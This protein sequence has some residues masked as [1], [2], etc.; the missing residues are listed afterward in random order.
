MMMLAPG[1]HQRT[2]DVREA[3]YARLEQCLQALSMRYRRECAEVSPGDAKHAALAKLYAGAQR[4]HQAVREGAVADA[5][6]EIGSN[7]MG[8][9]Q[10]AVMVARGKRKNIAF[11][12]SVGLNRKQLKAVRM[13][14]REIIEEAATDSVYIA[15]DGQRPNPV[16]QSLGITA[17][18]PF[19]LDYTTKGAIAFFELL[20]QR[21]GLDSTD[22]ELLTLLGA[23]AGPCLSTSKTRP[24][25]TFE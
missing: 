17:F 18:V 14:A 7:L 13:N 11:I 5:L 19:W 23:Y 22:R 3:D 15:D 4:L 9:E 20:P 2:R 21:N 12:G 16:L 6:V 10:M 24:Q 8:C 1:P 25:E